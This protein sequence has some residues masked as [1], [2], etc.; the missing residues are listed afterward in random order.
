MENRPVRLFRPERNERDGQ[1][2]GEKHLDGPVTVNGD[3][4][5]SECNA[6]DERGRCGLWNLCRC[7]REVD[8]VLRGRE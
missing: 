7:L 4:R 3:A 8:G 5:R 6:A 1:V 2:E